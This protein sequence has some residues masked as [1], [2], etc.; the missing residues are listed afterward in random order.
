M[1]LFQILSN[2]TMSNMTI[3]GIQNLLTFSLVLIY[4]NCACSQSQSS[5]SNTDVKTGNDTIAAINQMF[6][7]DEFAVFNNAFIRERDIL[8][9]TDLDLPKDTF[10]VNDSVFAILTRNNSQISLSL[11]ELMPQLYLIKIRNKEENASLNMIIEK[12]K[13]EFKVLDSICYEN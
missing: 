13:S 10:L 11:E 4:F 2:K 1:A 6:S 12:V 3:K 9:E 8:V 5:I 7:S